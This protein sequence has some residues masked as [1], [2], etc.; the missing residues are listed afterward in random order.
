MN[1]IVKLQLTPYGFKVFKCLWTHISINDDF[2]FV[3]LGMKCAKSWFLVGRLCQLTTL[4][5]YIE[6]NCFTHDLYYLLIWD[7][8]KMFKKYR[9][10]AMIVP[11][12]FW[13]F[14]LWLR[15]CHFNPLFYWIVKCATLFVCIAYHFNLIYKYQRP[16]YSET[17]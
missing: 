5:I 14:D 9:S 15:T 2:L 10:M 12:L 3:E 16:W 4:L 13:I 6:I 17:F 8:L 7:I 11:W 1:T